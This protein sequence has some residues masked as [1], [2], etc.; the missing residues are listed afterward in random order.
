MTD[1]ASEG[2]LDITV[3]LGLRA[4][5]DNPWVLPR[6]RLWAAHYRPRPSVIVVDMGSPGPYAEQVD[7]I[8][9]EEGFRRIRI[10]DDGLYSQS[11]ARNAGAMAAPTDLIFFCD[12][13]CI[14]ERDLFLRLRDHAEALDLRRCFDQLVVLPAYH[15]EAEAS[16][17]ILNVPAKRRSEHLSRAFVDALHAPR[18]DV[19]E[20]VDPFSN[21]F[22]CHRDFFSLTGGYDP[23]FRG[24]G[25]E[26]FELMIRSALHSGHLPIPE[27]LA[28]DLRGP[29]D[30]GFW[31]VRPYEGFRRLGE[32]TALQAELAG[33]RVA[34]LH[35]DRARQKD[36]WYR[37]N[38]WKRDRFTPRVERARSG[39]TG[40][41]RSDGL[42]RTSRRVA[43]V[44]ADW[45]ASVLLAL[46]LDGV[47]LEVVAPETLDR[48]PEEILS[49]T[50]C[51]ELVYVAAGSADRG[52]PLALA[53]KARGWKVHR[54]CRGQSEQLWHLHDVDRPPSRFIGARSEGFRIERFG[55]SHPREFVRAL[56]TRPL[57]PTS[58]A[59]ARIGQAI[60]GG[61]GV[62]EVLPEELWRWLP[63]RLRE[64]STARRRLRKLRKLLRD[65]RKF[66]E[67]SRLVERARGKR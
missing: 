10:D 60:R 50:D 23:S 29:T 22:L 35:H 56:E 1:T 48:A 37:E 51:G 14:G 30:P 26:D 5:S 39:W 16:Q 45:H 41:L 11:I 59:A 55:G 66:L 13:D 58:F 34:H 40:L 44:R 4:H 7:A 18:G 28:E 65:P 62:T 57:T 63:R 8:C 32:A 38:D 61:E 42:E 43:L 46:R 3:V 6:L 49:D 53:A 20:L 64:E 12:V 9:R 54:V 15:L 27:R 19:A 36:A 31:G 17:A 25:S 47:G 2:E 24:H 21:I 33:L 67:D 52:G